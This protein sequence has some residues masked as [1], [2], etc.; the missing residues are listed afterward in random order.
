VASPKPGPGRR[1]SRQSA[2]AFD[3]TTGRLTL[4]GDRERNDTWVLGPKG[5]S[6]LSVHPSPP[7]G[8]AS[9]VSTPQGLYVLVRNELWRLHARRWTHV[10]T[11]ESLGLFSGDA[12]FLFYDRRRS[13]LGT[14]CGQGV[15]FFD[16]VRWHRVAELALAPPETDKKFTSRHPFSNM[17]LDGYD[18]TVAFDP[19]GHR[20][21]ALA[22]GATLQLPLAGLELPRV[23]EGPAPALS[24]PAAES[25][26]ALKTAAPRFARPPAPWSRAAAQL[27]W[28]RSVKAPARLPVRERTGYEL[29][30]TLPASRELDLGGRGGLAVFLWEE[31][32]A[33]SAAKAVRVELLPKGRKVPA[34]ALDPK[35][36]RLRPV[37]SRPFTD[38]DPDHLDEVDTTPGEELAHDSK[39]GGYPRFIQS[40]EEGKLRCGQCRARLR[41]AAQFSPDLF[42]GSLFGDTGSLY[43]YV[44]PKGHQ[45]RGILQSC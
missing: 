35:L 38:V 23:Q 42:G 45:G 7:R 17:F 29:I 39:V 10:A 22:S 16:G 33:V 9:A 26:R 25:L 24:T 34:L 2:I 4:F 43:L 14:V 37:R 41:F 15:F 20:L 31:P 36:K 44:C 13:L 19:A 27:L 11:E 40:A 5:W 3:E 32:F 8:V 21:L 6:R 12:S 1:A 30:A 28:A 18:G